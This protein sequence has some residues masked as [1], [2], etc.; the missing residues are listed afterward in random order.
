MVMAPIHRGLPSSIVPIPIAMR[1]P[2]LLLT[3]LV[4]LLLT[5]SLAMAQTAIHDATIT[6]P[7]TNPDASA[8]LD[9][10]ST[11][12]GMLV[13]RVSLTGPND[14][15]TVPTPA[16]SL[17]VFNLSSSG[18]L[19]PGYYY[20]SGTSGSPAWV[21]LMSGNTPPLL[22][23]VDPTFSN[24]GNQTNAIGRTGNITFT[25]TSTS[26]GNIIF[27]GTSVR[28]ALQLANNNIT[29][30]NHITI[31]DP[32]VSEGITWTGSAGPWTLDVSPLGRSNADGN[33]NIYGT[34]NNIA[35]WR[36]T[37]FVSNGTNYTTATP[38]ASGGLHF[39]STGNGHLTFSPGGTGNVGIGTT[40]PGAKLDVNGSALI[41][42]TERVIKTAHAAGS[43]NYHLELYSDDTG[44][45]A[46][47]VSLRFHQGNRYYNQIRVRSGG[48]RFTQG[49]DDVL[50]AASMGN[51]TATGTVTFGTLASAGNRLVQANTS[52]VLSA[53]GIDPATITTTA[54]ISGTT[55][56]VAKFTA[57]NSIGN[58]QIFDNG[59]NVGVGTTSNAYKLDVNGSIGLNRNNIHFQPSGGSIAT[60]GTYGIY[61]HNSG[62][63][64]PSSDYGIY[65]TSGAWTASTYQQ[66]RLQWATGIELGTSASYDKSYVN[67]VSGKGLMVSAGNVGIGNTS[68]SEKLHVTG[69]TLVSNHVSLE[70]GNGKGYRFWNSDSYKIHMGNT[71]EYQY[72]PVTSYS[73]KTNMTSNSDRGWTWGVSGSAP[74]MAVN[75][76]QGHMRLRGALNLSCEACGSATA[77]DAF[78]ASGSGWGNVVI[79]GRVISANSNLHL[80]PPGGFNVV[81]N[82]T[83]RAAGG[84]STGAA[85]LQ[86]ESLA[87]T[88]SRPV[89]ADV[90][91]T[92]QA[93]QDA[94]HLWTISANFASS[95]DDFNPG[96]V[97]A[98][99]DD[100]R[101]V[102]GLGF[103]VVIEGVTYNSITI[104]TNGWVAFGD[105]N[106]TALFNTELPASF[107]NNP[108][109][110]PYWDDLRDY[111]SGEY[112][113]VATQ[114]TAPN[115]VAIVYYR[116]RVYGQD[117]VVHFQVQ[118]H[119][120][121][122][123]INVKYFDPMHPSANGQSAT[124][125]FQL[126][127][128]ANAKAY[129]LGY[130]VKILDDNRDDS[131]GWS[132]SP[133]R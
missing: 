55:N 128:G 24:G 9:A 15:S 12:K 100:A 51:L 104:C 38:Q 107:T 108:V 94:N 132:V 133:V 41:R 63:S 54:N 71:A 119:E 5:V 101:H 46:N 115:R 10:K 98:E 93:G 130:N 112:V 40:G 56:Y 114:G 82:D 69:N 83:Y 25:A 95:P 26:N 3:V 13:P 29:N 109:I 103:N 45:S 80:S 39:T 6:G 28:D 97:M 96:N 67:I 14:A 120:G 19:T 64:S 59:T 118:I 126:H 11:D 99:A 102:H 49:N 92:L 123:L 91:G 66:L 58:S 127:G 35:L 90:N 87:G 31:N 131:E 21:R 60:D 117:W 43:N 129:P 50:A 8:V 75:A 37:L 125:G 47:E 116:M 36:P 68:P 30:V 122:G 79:Q 33:F 18:G 105:V 20:N 124:I 78:P 86:V 110:F 72:G 89:Y 61:W 23:E 2:I 53:S 1:S 85:G 4:G 52:G 76:T 34:A 42:G 22:V 113:R 88:G 65:R 70:S 111:G 7:A 84:S 16:T 32:G 17:L 106:S 73:I 57:A 121:S 27:A 44:N 62:G 48:F 74:V 77:N 81:I